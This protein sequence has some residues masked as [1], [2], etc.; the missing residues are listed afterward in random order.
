MAAMKCALIWLLAVAPLAAETWSLKKLYTRPFVWGTSPSEVTWSKQGHVLLFLWNADGNRFL[1]LYSYNPDQKKLTRRTQMEAVRDILNRTE[2]E[3]DD[4]RKTYLMPRE[5]ITAFRLSRD[6]THAAF[7]YDGEVYIVPSDGS[8]QPFRLTRTKSAETKPQLSADAGKVSY[9]RDGQ[10][11]IQDFKSGQLWQVTD[12]EEKDSSLGDTGWS[13]DGRRFFYS[14]RA[15]KPRQL[16]LPNY[17]GR[18]VSARTFDRSL[19][20]DEAPETRIYVIGADGIKSLEMQPPEWGAKTYGDPPEWS[21]DSRNLVRR[22]IH[23]NLK[24]QQLLVLD[25]AAGK[26]RVVFEQSDAAWA[27]LS[28]FGWSPD[29]SH[30]FFTNDRDGFEHLYKIPAQG[31]KAEQLTRGAWE[32]HKERSFARDPQR[33]GDYLY[34][35]S[36]ENG[37]SE[38]QFYRIHPDGSGK[39]RLSKREGINIGSVSAD[40][41]Y[42]AMLEADLDNPFDLYVNGR[43]VTTSPRPEFSRY[44]WPRTSIRRVSIAA[45]PQDRGGQN[46]APARL[47]TRGTK[48]KTFADRSIYSWLRI[49][50]QRPEAVGQ[51][52][53]AALRIQLLPGEQRVRG[54]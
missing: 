26:T 47:P 42:T 29:S 46:P 34:F 6:G 36:T 51:L 23:P 20:G 30:I 48:P 32:I 12:I 3:K 50:N 2:A 17:S 10:L 9:E 28:S 11:F 54:A 4:R 14:V 37:P 15:G 21:P 52:S 43:R 13:P 39:E 38:R 25:P 24:R 40:G 49:R 7:A 22:V 8:A 41:E 18:F 16:V 53:G 27:E 44:Q 45:R 1:D 31:G 33:V 19:A 35:S 5:G